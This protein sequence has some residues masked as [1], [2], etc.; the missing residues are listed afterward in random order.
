MSRRLDRFHCLDH[1]YPPALYIRNI[2]GTRSY[3][4]LLSVKNELSQTVA[5]FFTSTNSLV[6]ARGGLR[7]LQKRYVAAGLKVRSFP[8]VLDVR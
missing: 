6:E 7:M 2:D 1:T 8:C 3:M 5:Y 4:A